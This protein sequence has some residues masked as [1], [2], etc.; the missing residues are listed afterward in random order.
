MNNLSAPCAIAVYCGSSA[1]NNP[2][3][4]QAAR[5]IGRL[6]AQ[7]RIR[8]IYGGG[9]VGLMGILADAAL[10]HGGAVIGVIPR[11]LMDRELA[12]PGLQT[13]HVTDT[14]H[15]RKAR[16]LALSGGCIALP[17]GI[18][19]LDELFEHWT[20]KHLGANDAPCAL[21][22]I[23]GYYD[24]LL[25]FLDRAVSDG[26]LPHHVRDMLTVDSSAER[27]LQRFGYSSRIE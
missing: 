8:M 14:M 6:F 11:M 15:E 9:R 21:L 12:H 2:A 5:D 26:L 24:P 16:M 27:L 20:L 3:F 23:E 13:L 7:H 19:T 1:G 18:G 22:N 25:Q 17:G 10:E 4:A